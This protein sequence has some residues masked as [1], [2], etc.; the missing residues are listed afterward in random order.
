MLA[1][2]AAN[3]GQWV[4]SDLTLNTPG[5]AEGPPNAFISEQFLSGLFNDPEPGN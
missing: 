4:H 3:L 5:V 1:I 2:T